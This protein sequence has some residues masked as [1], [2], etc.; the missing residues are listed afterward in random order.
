[1]VANPDLE[2]VAPSRSTASSPRWL[3]Y[4]FRYCPGPAEIIDT[5]AELGL[6]GVFLRPISPYGFALRRRGGANY[7]VDRWLEFYAAG[8]DR[9][10]ELNR[11]GVPMVEMYAS[12]I[13]K[14]ML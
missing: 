11:R 8:L 9:I 2:R 7:D 1:M 6:R 10:V 5:Y 3:L 13:A 14:K 4:S 12:I